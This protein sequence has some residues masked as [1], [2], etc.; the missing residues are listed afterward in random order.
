MIARRRVKLPEKDGS[1][2]QVSQ[3]KVDPDNR[4]DE[5]NRMHW[6]LL[7]FISGIMQGV[8]RMGFEHAAV[9]AR[10]R[11]AVFLV[12]AGCTLLGAGVAIWPSDRT[13]N[14]PY[15]LHASATSGQCE[16]KTNLIP[17]GQVRESIVEAVFCALPNRASATA[18]F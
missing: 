11:I 18:R 5:W 16:Q 9:W 8:G 4:S 15:Q 3:I 2:R 12:W 14:K 13:K 6:L 1:E 17:V 7:A 10:P